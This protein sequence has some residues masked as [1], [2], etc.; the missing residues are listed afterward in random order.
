[1]EI[2]PRKMRHQWTPA[3]FYQTR[4]TIRRW[5]CVSDWGEIFEAEKTV[6]IA[7]RLSPPAVLKRQ[8]YRKYITD[9]PLISLSGSS[10]VQGQGGELSLLKAK[11][12][13]IRPHCGVYCV[14]R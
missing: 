14:L 4:H 11:G 6:N 13:F 5:R 7:N 3:D 12:F 8:K 2:F 1:M 9:V 10:Q